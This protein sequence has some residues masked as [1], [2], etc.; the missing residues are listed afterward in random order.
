MIVDFGMALDRRITLEHAIR[1]GARYAAVNT[2]CTAIQ[3]TA[4]AQAQGII[5][6]DQVLVSYSANPARLGDA[7]N[8]S[9]QFDYEPQII[10]TLTNLLGISAPT[11]SLGASA[12]ARL[13]LEVQDA[14]GCGW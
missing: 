4:A 3:Q 2:S 5:T 14:G 11:M 13:E 9:A 12:S 7:V 6:S 10:N 8:V 1:E